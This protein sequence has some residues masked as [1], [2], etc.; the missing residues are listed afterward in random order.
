MF[1]PFAQPLQ[2]SEACLRKNWCFRYR[3][4][5]EFIT[6]PQP[7]KVIVSTWREGDHLKEMLRFKDPKGRLNV[8]LSFRQLLV[9][10]RGF[11]WLLTLSHGDSANIQNTFKSSIS[12]I[13]LG[14]GPYRKLLNSL[15]TFNNGRTG[16]S[17]VFLLDMQLPSREDILRCKYWQASPSY[18]AEH[19]PSLYSYRKLYL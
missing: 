3:H 12:S 10:R 16:L 13:I 18:V 15:D 7:K 14:T 2:V 5:S 19:S 11:D 6:H 1:S 17:N 8:A 9:P 4:L